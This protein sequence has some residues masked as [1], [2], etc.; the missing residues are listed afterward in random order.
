MSKELISIWDLDPDYRKEPKTDF[1]CLLCQRD[2]KN[3]A[4][5]KA[6]HVVEGGSCICHPDDDQLHEGKPD[7]CGMYPVGPECCKKIPADYLSVLT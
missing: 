2:I 5:A 1:Y 6:V 3:K 4:T 7:D